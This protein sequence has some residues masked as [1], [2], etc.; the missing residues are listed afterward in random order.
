MESVEVF[1]ENCGKFLGFK[2]LGRGSKYYLNK[3]VVQFG[4]CKRNP[5]LIGSYC[6]SFCLKELNEG[7]KCE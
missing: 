7:R 1:C 3:G 5:N 4:R 6:N 2:S